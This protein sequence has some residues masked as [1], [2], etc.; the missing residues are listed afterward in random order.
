MCYTGNFSL[1]LY[2]YKKSRI[3]FGK[4]ENENPHELFTLLAVL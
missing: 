1:G 2:D 4:S 3:L